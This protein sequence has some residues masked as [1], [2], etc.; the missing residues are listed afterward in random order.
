VNQGGPT[1][2][3]VEARIQEFR[4]PI[5]R[6]A[7]LSAMQCQRVPVALLV[8]AHSVR[9][10]SAHRRSLSLM[11]ISFRANFIAQS[12]S[13]LKLHDVLK[14]CLGDISQRLL[15]QKSLVGRHEKVWKREE[16]RNL[17]S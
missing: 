17:I 6:Q 13:G 7:Q 15:G 12:I 1:S 5:P 14:R 11:Q 10:S 3:L 8:V 16:A 2:P 4:Q 9:G